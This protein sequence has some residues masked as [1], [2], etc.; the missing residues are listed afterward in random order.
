MQTI[1]NDQGCMLMQ[2][3]DNGKWKPWVLTPSFVPL[4]LSHMECGLC[5]A[6]SSPSRW[7]LR[8]KTQTAFINTTNSA[9][10]WNLLH[11]NIQELY[12]WVIGKLGNQPLNTI[13]AL[14]KITGKPISWFSW[15]WLGSLAWRN[16][17]FT[18]F[19]QVG[20]LATGP[21]ISEVTYGLE[22]LASTSKK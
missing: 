3:Y 21:V 22:R 6:I 18:Y 5:R 20:G 17:Q 13:S 19:Q 16:H 9:W 10:L 14:L 8:G 11:R 1:L 4:V 12:L 2:A 15:S 7:S